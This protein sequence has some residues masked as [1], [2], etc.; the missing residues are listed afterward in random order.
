MLRFSWASCFSPF[1][2]S[3]LVNCSIPQSAECPCGYLVFVLCLFKK[4]TKLL[5]PLFTSFHFG[6]QPVQAFR[7][8]RH[9]C[10]RIAF[11]CKPNM[12]GQWNFGT[13]PLG[14]HRSLHPAMGDQKFRNFLAPLIAVDAVKAGLKNFQ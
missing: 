13:D 10:F 4:I 3:G 7:P 5:R 14:S 9:P 11:S 6:L 12:P 8:F 2:S 1:V